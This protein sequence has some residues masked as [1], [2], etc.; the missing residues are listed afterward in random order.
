MNRQERKYYLALCKRAGLDASEITDH[1]EHGLCIS[2]SGLRK[3]AA[4]APNPAPAYYLLAWLAQQ[5]RREFHIVDNEQ[6]HRS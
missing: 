4:I 1:P 2:P 3:L 6:K 5:R